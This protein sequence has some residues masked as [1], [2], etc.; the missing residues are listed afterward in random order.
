MATA[1]IDDPEMVQAMLQAKRAA[2]DSAEKTLIDAMAAKNFMLDAYQQNMAMESIESKDT[3][4][5]AYKQHCIFVDTCASALSSIQQELNNFL[6]A[7][8]EMSWSGDHGVH[9]STIPSIKPKNRVQTTS[10]TC[11]RQPARPPPANLL[12]ERH[13]TAHNPSADAP[14]PW[15]YKRR[16]YEAA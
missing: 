13:I 9:E 14:S 12:N 4:L 3:M 10:T 2:V 15:W 1:T 5:K 6:D 16:R 7:S 8:L 11:P